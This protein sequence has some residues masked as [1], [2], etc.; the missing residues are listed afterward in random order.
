MS[1]RKIKLCAVT[2]EAREKVAGFIKKGDTILVKGSRAMRMEEIVAELESQF[3][4]T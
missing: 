1:E 2:R 4:T 3:K